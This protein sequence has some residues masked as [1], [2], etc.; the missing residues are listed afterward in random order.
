MKNTTGNPS[1]EPEK[2]AMDTEATAEQ[3][4]VVQST[5]EMHT[6]NINKNTCVICKSNE[7][8]FVNYPCECCAFCKKCAMKMATG[9]KCKVCH[10]IFSSMKGAYTHG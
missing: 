1:Y 10:Q 8:G 2:E 6:P 5:E 3:C 9:G 4:A 7:V